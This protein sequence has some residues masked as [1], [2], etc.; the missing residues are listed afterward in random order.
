ME[1][2]RKKQDSEETNRSHYVRYEV[3]N[4]RPTDMRQNK[5]RRTFLAGGKR[6]EVK[7]SKGEVWKKKHDKK[8]ALNRQKNKQQ[9]NEGTS[10]REDGIDTGNKYDA[11]NRLEDDNEELEILKGRI[12]MD[13]FITKDIQPNGVEVKTWTSDMVRYFKDQKELKNIREEEELNDGR[14]DVMESN[15][16]IASELNAEE[17]R[18]LERRSL[19]KDLRGMKSITSGYPWILM[20]DFNV[21]LKIEEHSAGGSRSSRDMQDFMDCVNDIK[22]EDVNQ[23]GLLFTWIKSPSKPDTSIMKKLDRVMIN[24]EFLS[25]FSGSNARFHP[26]LI[27]D[28]IR[29]VMHIPNSLKGVKK[30]FRFSNFITDKVEFSD[31]VK[32]NWRCDCDGYNMYKLSLEDDLKKAQIKVEANPYDTKAKEDMT[33]ILHNYNEALNDEEKLLAQ[34]AKSR[35]MGISDE[36]GNWFEGEMIPDQF[37]KHFQAFLNKDGDNEQIEVEGLFKNI[38]S[39]NEANFMIREVSDKEVKDAMFGIGDDKAPG[40]DG[41]TAKF[42]KKS[43]E[44]T[45][46]DVCKA[47]REFFMANK[48]LGEVNATLITLVPKVQHP[49]KVSEYSPIACCN[50]MYKCISKII[51]NRIT[52]CLDKLVSIN[53]SAFVPGRLIQ[54]NLLITQELLKGYNRKSGPARCALKI[55]I[56]KAYDTVDWN[57]LEQI[58]KNFGFHDKFIGWVMTCVSSAAFSICLNGERHGYFKS[59]RGLRQ[60]DPMSPYLFTLVMEVLT[61]MVQ[62]RIERDNQF[63]YHWG[64]KEIKLAQLC[65]ANDLLMLCNGDYKSVEIL[66]KG[67]MEFSKTSGLIPNMRKSTIFFGSIKEVEK[68]RIL[69]VMPFKVGKLP[70]KYLGV[71]LITKNIRIT[72]CN[73]LVERVKQKA[74]VFLIPK[75]TVKEI[76][77]AL[78]GFLWCQENLK[79]GAAKVAWKVICSPKSQGGLGIKSLGPWNEALLCKHLWNIIDNKDS[80]W[81]KWVNVVKLKG[82]SIW[83]VQSENKDSGTWKAI[84]NLRCKIIDSVWKKVEDG[85]NTNMWFDKWCDEGPLCDLIPFRS[86]YEARL[87]E[88]TKVADMI[89]NN[90]WAWPDDWKTKFCSITRI[91]VPTLKDGNTYYAIWK[92]NNDRNDKFSIRKIWEKF[93]DVKDEVKWHKVVWFSQCNLRH[94]FIL[95]LIIQRRLP[96]KID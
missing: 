66:K 45:G 26:F 6:N 61:L 57:F 91:K 74:S 77:K 73:Q 32:Q 88:K 94:A 16:G 59:G 29:V 37:V 17:V 22:V 69:E 14:E 30:A 15:S 24:F 11:L 36:K 90:E 84:L 54:D 19:W 62:R 64:C 33:S 56:A 50:V 28:H 2:D 46:N 70:M 23:S 10:Q 76:E 49:N 95:W 21:T 1:E 42:F 82:K 80:L 60:G 71:P 7:G 67:L 43:W 8:E 63:K 5:E 38:L 53:Q 89:V 3:G 48:M 81:V 27:S 92:D 96:T 44:V 55:D 40:P 35:I 12:I 13:R 85:K 47:V 83:E 9:V 51:T 34:K 41:F 4:R 87:D 72:E 78:K 58:M 93:K 86:R 20:G 18:G 25:R 31:V 75:T 65:F 52:G 79:K 39:P 68:K